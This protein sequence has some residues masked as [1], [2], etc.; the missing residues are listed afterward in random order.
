MVDSEHT[1]LEREITYSTLDSLTRKAEVSKKRWEA[2]RQGV[3]SIR[4]LAKD[5]ILFRS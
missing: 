1:D 3:S 5:E 4:K 2:V